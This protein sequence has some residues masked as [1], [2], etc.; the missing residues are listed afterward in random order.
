MEM[1]ESLATIPQPTLLALAAVLPREPGA[2]LPR[3][4]R[5]LRRRAAQVRAAEVPPGPG[6][7]H[8]E[9]DLPGRE[10]ERKSSSRERGGGREMI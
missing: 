3:L 8:V 1:M 7:V 6:L 4:D 5:R 2:E 10:G 9:Q